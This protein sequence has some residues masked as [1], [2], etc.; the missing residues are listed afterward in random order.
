VTVGS[1]FKRLAIFITAG[2]MTTALSGC[3]GDDQDDGGSASDASKTGTVS[4]A[5]EAT[6]PDPITAAGADR[7]HL[8]DLQLSRLSIPS[9]DWMVSAFGSL[10][11]KRDDGAVTRVDPETGKVIAETGPSRPPAEIC[12]GIGAS[13]DAIWSCPRVGSITRIDPATNSTATTVRIAKLAVQGRIVSAADRVWVITD[14]GKLTAIDPRDDKPGTSVALDSAC[15]ELAAA[16]TTVWAMCPD[17]NRFLRVDAAAGKVTGELELAGAT[18]ASASEHLWVGF[19]GGLAQI[20]PETLDVL[21]VYDVHPRHGGSIFA[22]PD[23][24]WVREE[25]DRFLIRIDPKSQRIVE[26]IA[27]PDLPS[28]GDV[29]QIGDSVWATAYDDST[30]V[31]MRV[32]R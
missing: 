14:T 5:E 8:S 22:T 21:A 1:I 30:L 12:Q 26:T 24:V 15:A 16:G 28:G 4:S 23:A 31:E 18:N 7:L 29:V 2:L 10:W 9:P 17:D 6:L 27:A 25:G 19:E 13:D 32:S 20:E 3:G 11:V